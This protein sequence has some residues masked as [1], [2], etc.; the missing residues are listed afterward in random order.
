VLI[1][2]AATI[3][4]ISIKLKNALALPLLRSSFDRA[5]PSLWC[6]K[7]FRHVYRHRRPTAVSRLL[8]NLLS[9]TLP[10]A[11]VSS[12]SGKQLF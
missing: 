2:G 1:F 11:T 4:W 3:A 9:S 6:S 10:A 12:Q 5:S 8:L 7:P